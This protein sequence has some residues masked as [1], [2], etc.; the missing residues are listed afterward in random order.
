VFSKNIKISPNIYSFSHLQYFLT[1]ILA[2]GE[3]LG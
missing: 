2:M 3:E 1:S